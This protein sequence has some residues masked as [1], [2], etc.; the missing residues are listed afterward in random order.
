MSRLFPRQA[1]ASLLIAALLSSSLPALAQSDEQR[2]AAREIAMEG[3]KAYQAGKY[4]EAIDLLTKAESLYHAATHLLYLGRARAKL[5]HYVKAREAYLK[6][7]KEQLPASAPQAARDAQ[8]SASREV[9]EV[10]EKIGRLT[11]TVE[12]KEQAKDLVVS[13]DGAPVAQV[14]VGIPQPIDPGEHK[15]D[16]VATGFRAPQQLVTIA[17]AGR[18][19]IVL[20]LEPDASAVAPVPAVPVAAAAQPAP[21]PAAPA[22]PPPES[23]T[24]DTGT[25]SGTNGMR[26]GS[27]VAFGV[28][29]VGL[30]L[31]TVFLIQSGGTRSDADALCTLPNGACDQSVKDEVDA[32]DSDA[33][34]QATIGA[35]GLVTGVVAV[36]VGVTLFVLSGKKAK[37]SATVL[38][39]IGP[40]SAGISG[41]F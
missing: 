22:A 21:P 13:V 24:A 39:W 28:G 7:I 29:A 31:G 35:V 11:I 34:G 33:N 2:A 12:G 26:I 18:A 10:E 27:Y 4:D 37:K 30:G 38:P 3:V 41:T 1:F 5:G 8:Q 9:S 14:L 40:R 23:P 19:S 32:L 17:P 16:A 20:K 15:V 25:Q 6:L 36:G